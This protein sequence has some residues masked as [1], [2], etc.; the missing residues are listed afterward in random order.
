VVPVVSS[1][2]YA[3]VSVAFCDFTS[4]YLC[5]YRR[6]AGVELCI[7]SGFDEEMNEDKGQNIASLLFCAYVVEPVTK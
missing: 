7:K 4:L 1:E 6:T 3:L 2:S 5:Q